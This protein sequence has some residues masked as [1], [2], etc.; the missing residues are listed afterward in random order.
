MI[1]IGGMSAG[2]GLSLLDA[3]KDKSLSLIR[4]SA[5]HE[6]AITQF[7]ERIADVSS[8]DDL[9]EDRDLYTFV[10]RAH[11]LEDQ[12][13]NIILM[14]EVCDEKAKQ[15]KILIKQRLLERKERRKMER[16]KEREELNQKYQAELKKKNKNPAK[17]EKER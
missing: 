3:T 14:H 1:P 2:T 6:R 5:Q 7:R 11:D 16:A 13:S 9:M 17:W 15:E 4:N 8:I 10:M 12:I